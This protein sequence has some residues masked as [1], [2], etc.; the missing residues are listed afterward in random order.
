MES[1]DI[2]ITDESNIAFIFFILI[3]SMFKIVTLD[4]TR[5]SLKLASYLLRNLGY[6][7]FLLLPFLDPCCDSPSPK[8][9][10][11]LRTPKLLHL[12]GGAGNYIGRQRVPERNF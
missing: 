4:S 6:F 5:R 9:L 1:V 3:K 2:P 10:N 7:H 8:L 12:S 11:F